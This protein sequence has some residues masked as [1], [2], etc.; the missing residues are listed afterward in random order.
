MTPEVKVLIVEDRLPDAE[1]VERA[2]RKSDLRFTVTRVDQEPEFLRALEEFSPDLVLSDL[3]LP[4]FSGREALRLL[5]ERNP[6]VPLIFVSGTVGEETAIDLLK[7]GAADYVIKDNLARLVPA[8]ERTLNNVRLERE[9]RAS[10]EKYRDI[11]DRGMIGIFQVT[12]NGEYL[13]VNPAFA[14][15]HGYDSPGEMIEA[16][17]NMGAQVCVEPQRFQE[18]VEILDARGTLHDFQ[19]EH[20]CRDGGTIW[21]S[22][23]VR[24]VKDAEGRTVYFEGFA[25]DITR[26]KEA[27]A[28]LKAAQSRLIEASRYAG[29]AEVATNVLHNVGNVLNS[30]NVST[31]LLT[32]KLRNSTLPNLTRAVGLLRE[33]E[34]DL[35]TFLRDDPRGKQLVSFLDEL[36][37]CLEE[38]RSAFTAEIRALGN[39]IEHINSIVAMQQHY[40]SVRGVV[41]TVR[42]AEL[43]EDAL[44]MNIA[45]LGRHGVEIARDFADI[46]PVPLDRHKVLQIL[47]N[48]ISNAKYALGSLER[49]RLLSL[50][51]SAGEPG[52]IVFAVIDNGIGIPAENLTRIFEH[53]FSTRKDGHGFGLHSSALAARELG[54]LLTVLSEGPGRGATFLVDL[55]LLEGRSSSSAHVL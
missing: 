4:R 22:L 35:F 37:R 17:Q 50:R 47:V 10:E 3:S 53:G 45:G 27:E 16:I 18:A 48:L 33:Q 39:N 31:S 19:V 2:L 30:V 24:S 15:F 9:R 26:R 52:R 34:D 42:P 6:E 21:F 28:S 5:K 36:A 46:P 29:M 13:T 8:V 49:D 32:E 20:R 12:R 7:L 38:E 51:I 54:G 55:P 41:E 43:M 25:Q 40:T 14:R 11:F 1:L 44:R 23:D